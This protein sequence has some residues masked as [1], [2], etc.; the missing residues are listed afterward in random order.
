MSAQSIHLTGNLT[1]DPELRFTQGGRPVAS[2][3][4][5]VNAR[6]RDAAGEWKDGDPFFQRCVAWGK[7]AENVAESVERGSSVMVTGRLEQR[8]WEAEDGSKRY[9]VEL[10][11]AEVGVTLSRATARVQR[12]RR[13]AAAA[14]TAEARAA[15]YV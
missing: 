14:A 2:F 3:T 4:V 9:A 15:A 5:A 13:D 10:I 7:L 11:V 1:A 12:Q 6:F 8:S